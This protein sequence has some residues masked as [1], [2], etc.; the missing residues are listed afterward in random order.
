MW[1]VRGR[2]GFCF[3]FVFFSPPMKLI[4]GL[5]TASAVDYEKLYEAVDFE[6]HCQVIRQCDLAV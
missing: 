6:K 1:L 4:N 2:S 5:L 3:V